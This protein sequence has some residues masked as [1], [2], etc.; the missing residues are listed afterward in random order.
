MS[1]S[2]FDYKVLDI[3][4]DLNNPNLADQTIAAHAKQG[5]DV[6]QVFSRWVGN[7]TER[8]YALLRRDRAKDPKAKIV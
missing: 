1:L 3:T 2:E 6:Q 7:D 8:V 5:W 4:N